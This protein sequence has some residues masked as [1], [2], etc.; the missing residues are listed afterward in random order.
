MVEYNKQIADIEAEIRKT[1]SN[2]ATRHHIGE[3]IARS[4]F[5]RTRTIRGSALC[6]KDKA[7]PRCSP[8]SLTTVIHKT[9][10]VNSRRIRHRKAVMTSRPITGACIPAR[11]QM[12]LPS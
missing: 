1:K 9:I 10:L 5:F 3:V 4:P 8:P 2:K 6:V 11:L 7:S 12:L